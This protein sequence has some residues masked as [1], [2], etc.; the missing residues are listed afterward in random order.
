MRLY[1]FINKKNKIFSNV[2]R[3]KKNPLK[4]EKI[5]G[6]TSN[7]TKFFED[8]TPLEYVYITHKDTG[9]ILSLLAFDPSPPK[10]YK[11]FNKSASELGSPKVLIKFLWVHNDYV[12]EFAGEALLD[13]LLNTLYWHKS[14]ACITIPGFPHYVYE[15]L[16][17]FKFVQ[18][19]PTYYGFDFMYR[20]G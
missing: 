11:E 10:Y 20:K 7:F 9:N 15:I 4:S 19:V 2:V 3:T 8:R 17:N 5:P 16:H 13:Y 6:F 18:Y 1:E 14:C 12:K